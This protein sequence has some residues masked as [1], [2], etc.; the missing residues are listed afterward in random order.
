[1]KADS[2]AVA[3]TYQ[4]HEEPLSLHT[5][6]EL[7]IGLRRKP[8]A[9]TTKYYVARITPKGKTHSVGGIY[10]DGFMK[11]SVRELG[12]YTVAMDT[13]PPEITPVGKN[14]WVKNEKIVYRIEDKE[15]G[16]R[17]FRGTIDGK[18]ALFGRPIW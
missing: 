13:V 17:S 15:T 2:G 16:I 4:L 1:M 8:V 11:T 18:Y 6:A 14:L 3:F 9:D 7:R 12:T 10:E 5:S